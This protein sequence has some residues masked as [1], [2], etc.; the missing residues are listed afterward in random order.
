MSGALDGV[1]VLSLE[2]ATVLPFL[3]Y[4]LACDGARV[5][6]VENAA[7]PDPNRFVGRDV[8][9]EP[10]MRSYFLPNNCGKE[11]ITL[12]LAEAEGRA[13]L[14]ELLR[15]LRVDVFATNQRPRSYARLGID[16]P[17]LAAVVPALV[18]LG[19]SGFGPGHDEAAYDPILQAR[20]G[21]MELTGEPDG[22]PTVFGLPMVDLGAAEHGYGELLKALYRRA[23]TGRGARVDVSMLR[24]AVSWMIAPLALA[25][26]LGERVARRGNTHQFFA[27]VAVFATRDAWVY[28]AVGNDAQWAALARLPALAG[29]DRPEYAANAGRIADAPRLHRELGARFARLAADE[30]LALLRGAGVPVARVATLADVAADPLVAPTL[31]RVRDPRTGLEVLLPAPPAGDPPPLSFPP[32]LGEHN[33]KIYGEA[34]GYPPERLAELRARRII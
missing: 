16:Y 7:H 15:A 24:S 25:R 13:L 26:G 30:A 29:V 31:V 28:V 6:R 17:T 3:T 27:P 21:F 10:A 1:T 32:R 23:R 12:N 33:E 14:L 11:A 8:L 20:A 19:I 22:P 9:G 2:Q 34:L 4:R 18:W 5:I